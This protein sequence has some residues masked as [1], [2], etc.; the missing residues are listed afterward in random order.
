MEIAYGD[1]ETG[2]HVNSPV[3]ESAI[4]AL[5]SDGFLRVVLPKSQPRRIPLGPAS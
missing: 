2:V 3:E 4:E 1:F 5:Y